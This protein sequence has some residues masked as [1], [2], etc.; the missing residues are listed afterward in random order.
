MTSIPMDNEVFHYMYLST[1]IHI[2]YPLNAKSF[3]YILYHYSLTI[4]IVTL[5]FQAAFIVYFDSIYKCVS[6]CVIKK[7]NVL[8]AY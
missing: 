2:Y 1:Y 4:F 7:C 5:Y 8:L 3:F 6:E